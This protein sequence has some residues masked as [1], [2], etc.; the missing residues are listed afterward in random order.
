MLCWLRAYVMG[1]NA[2]TY[3]RYRY[4]SG[5]WGV[6]AMPANSIDTL[7]NKKRGCYNRA[8]LLTNQLT[9]NTTQT[10]ISFRS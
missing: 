5:G 10:T 7:L 2:G 9:T 8:P 3:F 1:R 6:L 4:N